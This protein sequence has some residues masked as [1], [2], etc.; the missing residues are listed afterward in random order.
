[1]KEERQKRG[2][3]QDQL[4]RLVGV[5]TAAISAIERGATKE[6][7][8]S[9]GMAIAKELRVDPQKL[10]LSPDQE[11]LNTGAQPERRADMNTS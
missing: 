8:L 1:M 3:T 2:L 9:V 11:Q 10:F 5:T 4:A 7:S 6:P